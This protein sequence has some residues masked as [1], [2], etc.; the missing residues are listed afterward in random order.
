MRK[1]L[2]ALV[3]LTG[4][5]SSTNAAT[6]PTGG[7]ALPAST[8]ADAP[9]PDAATPAALQRLNHVVVIFLEAFKAMR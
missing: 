3:T 8:S 1:A 5:C 4:A 2:L 9:T 7:A 6:P